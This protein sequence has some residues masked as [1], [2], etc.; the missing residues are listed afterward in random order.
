MAQYSDKRYIC[1]TFEMHLHMFSFFLRS[2]DII[3][4]EKVY[5]QSAI[6][7]LCMA[8]F[9]RFPLFFKDFTNLSQVSIQ[10]HGTHLMAKRRQRLNCL[11][12]GK[13]FSYHQLMIL[14]SLGRILPNLT[15]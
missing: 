14:R 6:G 2:Q 8:G 11:F 1:Q 9:L 7:F 5:A 15:K 12:Y 10:Y 3:M 4:I 13:Q